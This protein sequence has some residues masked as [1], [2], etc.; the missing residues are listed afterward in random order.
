MF[1]LIRGLF[2]RDKYAY[3][4]EEI[5]K[6]EKELALLNAWQLAAVIRESE[7]CNRDHQKRIVAE[8]LLSVRLATIQAGATKLSAWINVAGALLAT[9]LGF[10]IGK[11]S[12]SSLCSW[13]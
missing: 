2:A 5:S 9:G 8:H 10:F 11:F 13:F 1:V 12:S 4:W 6:E 7:E 3:W